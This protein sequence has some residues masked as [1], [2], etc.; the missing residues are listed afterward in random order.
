MSTRKTRSFDFER[1]E[2][3]RL[4]AADLGG[5]VIHC[6][7]M[8]AE[9]CIATS[10]VAYDSGAADVKPAETESGNCSGSTIKG[11]QSNTSE[12]DSE[13]ENH[14]G[15]SL[16]TNDSGETAE[17]VREEQI[18]STSVQRSVTEMRDPVLG[19]SGYFGELN[20]EN[21]SRSMTFTPSADGIIDIVVASSNDSS[22]IDLEV[23][24]R[25]GN[26]VPVT[27]SD[28]LDGF[29]QLTFAA[30]EGESYQLTLSSADVCGE[31]FMVT[32]DYSTIPEPVDDHGD[33]IG[34]ESTEMQMTDGIAHLSGNLE[35]SGDVDTFRFPAENDGRAILNLAETTAE[36]MT[37]LNVS[38]CD[39]SGNEVA[40]GSTN[41][42][43]RISFDVTEGSDYF[44]TVHASEDQTGSYQMDLEMESFPVASNPVDDHA[45]D[46]GNQATMLCLVDGNVSVTGSLEA[47][48]DRDAFRLV[49]SDDG[50]MVVNVK[51]T[52]DNHTSSTAVSVF[53]PDE[54]LVVTGQTNEE[55]AIRFDTV[56][57]FEYQVLIDATNDIRAEYE[58]TIRSV[59]AK[60][61]LLETSIELP[62]SLVNVLADV[63]NVQSE[64]EM[65]VCFSNDALENSLVDNV[66]VEY[67]RNLDTDSGDNLERRN[68]RR[69]TSGFR[70]S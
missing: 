44:V 70:R 46:I 7:D 17:T 11:V 9:I 41:E 59:K 16:E 52:S 47:S 39:S 58:L 4:L 61:E 62:T 19:T 38:V 45:N 60:K 25:C 36:N 37:E 23:S 31:H 63:Q 67:G 55:V 5:D 64:D 10:V 21:P 57:N 14:A 68:D 34:T 35:S 50:E 40:Q 30:V 12:P 24:D 8:P 51:T 22:S 65:V 54:K 3:R 66:F 29:D 48:E 27:A 28:Q 56:S 2:Q 1:L 13:F 20:L 26:A 15:E 33:S 69:G 42:S 32:V 49:A 18:E 43:V 6:N 53:G